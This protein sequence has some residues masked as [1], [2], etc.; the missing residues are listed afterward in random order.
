M[1]TAIGI[2]TFLAAV[3]AADW[4]YAQNGADWPD[5]SPDCGLT[6]QSPIDLKTDTSGYK[7]FG[8]ADDDI[9]K[10]YSNQY[11]ATVNWNGHTSQTNLGLDAATDKYTTVNMFKSKIAK[12]HFAAPEVFEGN[13][14]HF[15]AGSEHTI[16]GKR[17]DLEMHTVHF[18]KAPEGGFIAAAVG[19][20][21]S[22]NDYTAQL[23]N[24]E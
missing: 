19:I 9:T 20:M 11:G 22:V 3:Q 6:N 4:N 15:H 16:D 13:Q 7:I 10:I 21:F 2:S 5:I 8:S 24:D 18:P 17:Q 14:F 1:Q 12:N 23:T